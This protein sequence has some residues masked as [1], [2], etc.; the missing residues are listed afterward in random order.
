MDVVPSLRVRARLALIKMTLSPPTHSFIHSSR[1]PPGDTRRRVRAMDS[2]PKVSAL[3]SKLARDVSPVSGDPSASSK[4]DG[5]NASNNIPNGLENGDARARWSWR[6][7]FSRGGERPSS[8]LSVSRESSTI[9]ISP[10]TELPKHQETRETWQYPS[11][12]MFY[13]AMARKGWKPSANDMEHV[14]KIHNAVNEKA[15]AHVMAWERRHCDSCPDPKLLKFRGRPKDYSPKARFLNF[16]GYKLPFDRHDWVVD[17]CGT[18]VR[19]VID[20]YNAVSYG[21]VAPVA[22]HLDVRPALDSPSSAMDRL[23]V[24]LGWML[25]GEWARKPR[26]KPASD[27]ET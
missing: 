5:V 15:W 21:G 19:Y 6:W 1:P 24:Q 20:F 22:M 9:P 27:A 4:D 7:I 16:L 2:E 13:D 18:E 12:R 3:F 8:S 25:S 11:E 17:R 23:A 10:R 26:A 14:V